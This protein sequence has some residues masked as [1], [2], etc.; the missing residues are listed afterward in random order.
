MLNNRSFALFLLLTSLFSVLNQGCSRQNDRFLNRAFHNTT[1]RYNGYFNAKEAVK[2]GEKSFRE[3]IKPDYFELLPTYLK[4]DDKS[5]T[6]LKPF[7]DKAI[8]KCSNVIEYHSMDIKGE[9][10]CKWIDDCY[11]LIGKSHYYNRTF[12]EAQTAFN[13][14]FEKYPDEPSSYWAK[15]YEARSYLEQNNFKDAG[16]ALS[17]I[18]QKGIYPKNF[19]AELFR[20][21]AEL[22]IQQNN[23]EPALEAITR[24]TSYTK[25]KKQRAELFFI[26]AQLLKKLDRDDEA[27]RAYAKVEKSNPN[28][29]LLFYSK[30]NQATAVTGK[31]NA[32]LVK[33]DL[34]KLLSDDKNRDY[35][36]QLYYALGEVELRMKNREKAIAYF[37][38]ST[39]TEVKNPAQQTRSFLRLAELYFDERDFF[40][41]QMNYD[42]AVV[43]I[44]KDYK[45]VS[46]IKDKQKKLSELVGHLRIVQN[47]DSLLKLANLPESELN[48]RLKQIANKMMDDQRAA[49]SASEKNQTAPSLGSTNWYFY[50]DAVRSQGKMS[51]EQKWGARELEDFWR[52]EDKSGLDDILG[53]DVAEVEEIEIEE[54]SIDDLKKGLPMKED[55]QTEML[56]QIEEA[57]FSSGKLFKEYFNDLEGSAESFENLLSRYPNSDKKLTVYYLLYR[58]YLEREEGK[59]SFMSFDSKSSSFYYADLITYEFPDSEFAKIISNPNYLK[60]KGE[61]TQGEHKR[62]F[63]IYQ[64]FLNGNTALYIDSVQ[65]IISGPA[66]DLSP[67]YMLLLAK[68]QSD[69]QMFPMVVPTLEKLFSKYPNTPEGKEADRILKILKGQEE[70]KVEEVKSSFQ[71]KEDE[72]HYL[73]ILIENQY[74]SIN[75]AKINLSNF[76][77][78][79]FSN[80]KLTLSSTFLNN[81]MPLVLVKKFETASKAKDYHKVFDAKIGDYSKKIEGHKELVFLISRSNFIE[82]FKNKDLASYK[83][84]FNKQY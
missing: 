81:D 59:A 12:D 4:P 50:N 8:E 51:F 21:R 18:E 64:E 82:L 39:K 42:S 61:A 79:W 84:F 63:A 27:L 35:F 15:L 80:D 22:E 71:F 2:E 65:T 41:S 28:Y 78:K 69:L 36:D 16:L 11:F 66:N 77:K 10:K 33:G 7:M 25:K 83:D 24:A 32:P 60:E 52:F 20:T 47:N 3:G 38:K 19:G 53:E 70:P 9:E 58:N 44:P 62:Y 40:S 45:N 43:R 37:D 49:A 5:A 29:D 1:S 57:L 67:K 76:H 30:I 14:V 75:K 55:E 23:F 6:M 26:Q 13:Y 17:K 34:L 56:A 68:M 46:A 72:E 74:T 54:V 31:N 48:R 73:L